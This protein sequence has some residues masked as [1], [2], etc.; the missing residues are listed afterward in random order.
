[1]TS[2]ETTDAI[3]FQLERSTPLSVRL[4]RGSPLHAQPTAISHVAFGAGSD[5]VPQPRRAHLFRSSSSSP[6]Q[7]SSAQLCCV[8]T[9]GLLQPPPYSPEKVLRD[10]CDIHPLWQKRSKPSRLLSSPTTRSSR[11]SPSALDMIT[12]VDAHGAAPSPPFI[13]AMLLARGRPAEGGST[14][15]FN[16][17]GNRGCAQTSGVQMERG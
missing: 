5:R 1:M 15:E 17:P 9:T 14:G 3:P 12:S 2:V 11:T 6:C 7:L 16:C 10:G 13:S 8:V 4:S